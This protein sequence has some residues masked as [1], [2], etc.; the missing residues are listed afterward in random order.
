MPRFQWHATKLLKGTINRSV[1]ST[2][3]H[4]HKAMLSVLGAPMS[5]ASLEASVP[6]VSHP[7]ALKWAVHYPTQMLIVMVLKCASD[8]VGLQAQCAGL[9]EQLLEGLQ[10]PGPDSP[11]QEHRGPHALPERGESLHQS[12]EQCN[13]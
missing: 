2:G 11:H 7:Q 5:H 4:T 9:A 12:K 3:D 10:L 8:D 13:Q 6:G 1:C